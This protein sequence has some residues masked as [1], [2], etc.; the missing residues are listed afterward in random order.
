[1]GAQAAPP[2]RYWM[3]R[4][5][6]ETLTPGRLKIG[7][8]LIVCFVLII[9]SMLAGD[10]LILWQFH[11]VRAQAERLNGIDQT[12]VALLRVHT[13]LLAFHDR[14]GTLA[15]SEDAS[16]LVKEAGPLWAAV[17]EQ[18]QLAK[19]ALAQLPPEVQRDPT[20]LPT[21]EDIESTLPPQLDQIKTLA[22]WR[23]WRAVRRRLEVQIR[24]LESLTSAL[25]EKVDYEVA[26][27]QAQS[28][29]NT[30]RV[31]RRVFLIVPIT[32]FFTL[33]VAA[34]LGL[35]IT[36]S[37]TLPLK[38]LVEG[39]RAL[40]RSDFQ[41]Q[42]PIAGR[43][44]LADLGR[45]FNDTARRLQEL[46]ATLQSSEDRLRLAIDTVPSLIWTATPEGSVDFINQRWRE[47]TGLTV[48]EGLGWNWGEAV[49][50]DDIKRFV[51]E[52]RSALA[53]G[54]PM[55][56]EARVRAAD[57]QY[58]WLLIR[59]VP[60]RDEHGN[61]VKWYGSSIDIDAGKRA[62][63][64]LRK[65]Q[66]DLA[67]VTRVTTVGELVTSIAHEINQP[68]FGIVTSA[69]ACSRWLACDVPNLD[70]AR[71]AVRRIVRD[72]KRAG[73]VITRIRALVR[74]SEVAKTEL[75]INQTVEEIVGLT[76]N[77]ILRQ[78][79][80]FKTDLATDL[81]TVSG[82]R[83]QLQQVVLNL[84]LNGIEAMSAVSER[85]R[86]LLIRSARHGPDKVLIAVQDSGVGIPPQNIEEIF[87]A[88]YTTKPQ[89]MGMGLAIS[90]TIIE[91]H[92][93]RLWAEL[94]EGR[95]M[96]F[97]FTLV[98]YEHAHGSSEISEMV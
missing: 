38:R 30:R 59:N 61:I 23:D 68:L 94:N 77:E 75:D 88:F 98:N 74:K 82:D 70:E 4:A 47:F 31:E 33:L 29:E 90:R 17:Q 19:R 16:H 65:A 80:T 44:E 95:G 10:A 8:R 20:I 14:L 93:G 49:H 62:E 11:L 45:V 58:H 39:S 69:S 67:H 78:G 36:R 6:G 66:A 24:P 9:V 18:V 84:V 40:A 15:E 50:P 2:F 21:L 83:V 51:A 72:G 56:A 5:K 12:L 22:S 86:E 64:A 48:E 92:G 81:P 42:V 35:A 37:I 32:A 27:Q 76:Q 57:G 87:D 60:L 3:K 28:I 55:R 7:S 41:H 53:S 71:E 43:D 79:M 96:T 25:V 73:D 91:R 63:E 13:S 46:Y 26:E 97:L 85:P 1:M 89:G 52:W 54:K 34:S